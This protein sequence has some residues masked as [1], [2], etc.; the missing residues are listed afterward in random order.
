M[1]PRTYEL[2]SRCVVIEDTN[3]LIHKEDVGGFGVEQLAEQ[4]SLL[5]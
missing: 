1:G 3:V 4:V 5:I 2:S